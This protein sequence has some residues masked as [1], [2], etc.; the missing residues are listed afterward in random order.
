MKR[1]FHVPFF[2]GKSPA[3]GLPTRRLNMEG[4]WNGA[5]GKNKYQYNEKEWNDDFGLGMNDY[6]ARFYDPAIARWHSVDP[7]AEKCVNL[8]PYNYVSNNPIAFIDPDGKQMMPTGDRKLIDEF[9]GMLNKNATGYTFSYNEKTKRIDHSEQLKDKGGKLIEANAYAQTI[10]GAIDDK[11]IV[12][13][14]LKEDPQGVLFDSYVNGDVNISDLRLLN[15]ESDVQSAFIA[16]FVTERHETPDYMQNR[17]TIA[18]NEQKYDAIY[19]KAMGVREKVLGELNGAT[20]A[21]EQIDF[22]RGKGG[23]G[24]TYSGGGKE[25]AFAVETSKGSKNPM[26]G[27]PFENV[28]KIT[29]LKNGQQSVYKKK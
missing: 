14:N 16:H 21:M 27:K 8:S 24:E 12:D 9:I 11:Q 3:K 4:D 7:L 10:V 18:G 19:E 25:L 23:W 22:R 15:K 29:V 26:T 2:G 28:K 5:Q 6:G 17:V 20:K 1:K 13:Y